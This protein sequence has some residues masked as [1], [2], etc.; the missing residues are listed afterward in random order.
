MSSPPVLLLQPLTSCQNFS[1][2]RDA[3]ASHPPSRKVSHPS[4]NIDDCFTGN[5]SLIMEE[6]GPRISLLTVEGQHMTSHAQVHAS[7]TWIGAVKSVNC[8]INTVRLFLGSVV[9]ARA[10]FN[11]HP[12]LQGILLRSSSQGG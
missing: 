12:Q 3:N 11:F 4:G 7:T 8:K 6:A 5:D 9:R 10:S 2:L 1:S